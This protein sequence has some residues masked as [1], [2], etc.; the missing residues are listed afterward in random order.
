M[1]IVELRL[2]TRL[3]SIPYHAVWWWHHWWCTAWRWLLEAL[4]A[5][6]WGTSLTT[7]EV[8]TLWDITKSSYDVILFNFSANLEV[9]HTILVVSVR[10]AIVSYFW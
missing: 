5:H 7:R 1:S 6:H 4:V 9:I 8:A 3:P 10:A 2:S